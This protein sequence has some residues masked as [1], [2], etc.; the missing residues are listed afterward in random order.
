[1]KNKKA[2][3]ISLAVIVVAII[4]VVCIYCFTPKKETQSV[5]IDDGKTV[6][7][8]VDE[9]YMQITEST[10]LMDYLNKLKSDGKIDYEYENELSP[11]IVSING[12]KANGDD[13]EFWGLYSNDEE[14]TNTAWG[15]VEYN[16]E[17]LGS[18]IY[19]IKELIIKANYIYVFKLSTW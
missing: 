3:F 6:V 13:N 19:G 11:F 14:H 1:M 15:T 9:N 4:C 16:G 12:V 7:I 8:T 17:I 5:E 18:T 2:I 10:T